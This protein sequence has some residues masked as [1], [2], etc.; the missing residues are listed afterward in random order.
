MNG[1]FQEIEKRV[2]SEEDRVFIREKMRVFEGSS[3]KK[4]LNCISDELFPYE[5]KYIKFYGKECNIL[6]TTVG[7]REA[8]IIF[9]LLSLRPNKG[10]LLHTSQSE[11]TADKVINDITISS[12]G[13][14]FEKVEIDEIDA[15]RN[16]QVLKAR[17]LSRVK[18]ARDVFVDPTGGRKVMG[19]SIAAFA[20]FYRVPMIYLHAEEKLSTPVPFSGIIREIPNPYE[21]YG[22]I[23]LSMLKR[24]FERYDFD[25]ALELCDRLE[26]TVC[27]PILCLKLQKIAK[28]IEI[29]RDWDAFLHSTHFPGNHPKEDIAKIN[30]ADRLDN[31][32]RNDLKRFGYTLVNEKILEANIEFLKYLQ[33]NWTNKKNICDIYRLIDLYVN[34]RRRAEQKKF[35][36]ATARLYRCLE[37]CSSIE[38]QKYG[39]KDP[40]NP[41]YDSFAK[42]I[43][44]D[45]DTLK[46][47][48]KETEKYEL[49]L[50]PGLRAQMA[51]LFLAS[52]KIATIYRLLDPRDESPEK[53]KDSVMEKRNR[54]ILAHGTNPITDVDYEYL[55][56][57]TL[58]IIIETVEDKNEFKIL[59]KKAI[60]PELMI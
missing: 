43:N 27:D 19:A 1:I 47:R 15:A 9:S 34:A 56:S 36:D 38:L 16:F 35:D 30:L 48:F 46:Q 6:I 23:E 44:M 28:L 8:P 57:R 59:S 7:M 2:N 13:I 17:V 32:Y 31:L 3:D 49:P 25:A 52:N 45:L 50:K 4:E 14:K 42:N 12:L 26:A 37:M 5:K 11:K 21:Y 55:D 22:D 24:H 58:S 54:S 18:N 41:D 10:I 33:E 40:S 51:L 29:Y 39:V 60:F 20:F 53:S